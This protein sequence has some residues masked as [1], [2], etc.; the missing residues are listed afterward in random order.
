MEPE[1]FIVWVTKWPY[2]KNAD[3][4]LVCYFPGDEVECTIKRAMQTGEFIDGPL[5]IPARI[6]TK[7]E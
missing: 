4:E 7:T 5:P 6:R 2:E 3:R 1:P